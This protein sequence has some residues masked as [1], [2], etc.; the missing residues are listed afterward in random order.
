MSSARPRPHI[1]SYSPPSPH[2]IIIIPAHR[3]AFDAGQVDGELRGV[4]VPI[5][6]PNKFAGAQ[7]V[8]SA[9]AGYAELAV[10]LRTIGKHHLRVQGVG[11]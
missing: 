5:V 3:D 9:L 6:P 7:H 2:L 1:A 11:K 10:T 8:A 4:W